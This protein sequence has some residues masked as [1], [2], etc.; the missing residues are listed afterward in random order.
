MPVNKR[1][2][3]ELSKRNPK[4]PSQEERRR[5]SVNYNELGG[6]GPP[7]GYNSRRGGDE[8]SG[9][10]GG[11]SS[12]RLRLIYGIITLIVLVALVAPLL[13]GCLPQGVATAYAAEEFV[14]EKTATV[15]SYS[16]ARYLKRDEAESPPTASVPAPTAPLVA[17]TV[18]VGETGHYIKGSLLNFWRSQGGKN[19]FGNPLSEEFEQNGRTVQYFERALLEYNP[20]DKG[21]R[22][23]VQLAFLGRQLVEAKGYNFS[24]SPDTT[25]TTNRTYFPQTGQAIRGNFKQFWDRNNGLAF[26][27]YPI[28]EDFSENNLTVQYFERGRLEAPPNA[29]VVVSNSGD[30]LIEAKGWW[31]PLKLPLELNIDDDEIYQGRTLAIRLD[32]GGLWL[33]QNLKGTVGD[34][35]LRF[36][37]VG[38][39][40]KAFNPFPITAEAKTYPMQIDFKDLAARN[41]QISIPITVLKFDFPAIRLI[42]PAET[43]DPVVEDAENKLLA[44]IYATF[45]PQA[46]WAGR[47]GLPSPN[48][49]PDNVTADFGQRRAYNDSPTFNVNHGGIDYAE[50]TGTPVYAATSGKVIFADNLKVRGGTVIIDHGLGVLSFY[51]HL[52]QITAKVG[53]SVKGGEVVGRVGNTG[54]STGPHLH[55]E[56]RVNGITTYPLTFQRLD[57][58]R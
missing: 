32:N 43:V 18:Y 3:K 14:A 6:G 27:G 42:V 20:A 45:T 41:R 4:G 25:S 35:T 36:L 22:N 55:W 39:S 15:P 2:R 33:P 44:P 34:T 26:L 29:A 9:G 50:N 38:S 28:S 17:D 13:I 53:A 31:R 58:S 51:F 5:Q 47:W 56:V 7:P 30:L 37:T 49:T 1:K 24:P 11:G 10:S 12:A 8:E 21:T 40:F 19:L 16:R 52:S 57:L 48:A 23:E 46:L 54:R